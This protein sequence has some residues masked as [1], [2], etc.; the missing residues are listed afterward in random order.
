MS[1]IRALPAVLALLAT[2]L[3][4]A[5]APAQPRDDAPPSLP[6]KQAVATVLVKDFLR[7]ENSGREVKAVEFL[8]Y[9]PKADHEQFPIARWLSAE[10]DAGEP[11]GFTIAA[12]NEDP[13]GNLVH[14]LRLARAPAGTGVTVTIT[15]L[16]LR[17]EQPL[18]RGN[19]PIPANADDY[20]EEVRPYLAS[21]PMVLHDHPTVRDKA[22]ELRDKADGD[23]IKFARQV[24]R[25]MNTKTYESEGNPDWSRP[26]S[27]VVLEHGGSCCVSAV[28]AAALFRSAGIPA[29]LTYTP[30]GYV[31]GIVQFYVPGHGS[32]RMDATCGASRVP[33]VQ[34]DDSRGLVRLFDTPIQMEEI[35]AAFAWPYY[36]NT[37]DAKYAFW[38]RGRKLNHIRFASLPSPDD[39]TGLGWVDEPFRHLVPG[40][41]NMVMGLNWWRIDDETWSRCAAASRDAVMSDQTGPLAPVLENLAAAGVDPKLSQVIERAERY[42]SLDPDK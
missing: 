4:T 20:P 42:G 11:I 29:Q 31:H 26:T 7:L 36:H 24:S 30:A 21:T 28:A 39:P 1:T 16:V 23:I 40:S 5:P 12:L 33:F 38:S 6:P 35:R 37:L 34:N 25:L 8:R 9:F 2:I 15:S 22:A 17:R 3:A 13:A 32:V 41:W 19:F 10:T 14:T 18:P 27:L